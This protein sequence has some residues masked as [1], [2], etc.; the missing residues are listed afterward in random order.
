MSLKT[1]LL[2]AGTVGALSG[3]IDGG[4]LKSSLIGAGAAVG[5]TL[6]IDSLT[7]KLPDVEKT[8]QQVL[9]VSLLTALAQ[10]TN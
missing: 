8:L 6:L 9:P 1:K 3:A 10:I 2:F 4:N 7:P 5:T